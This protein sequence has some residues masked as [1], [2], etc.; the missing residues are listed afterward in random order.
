MKTYND[1]NR[2]HELIGRYFDA[3]ASEAE[4]RELKQALASTKLLTAEIE[5]ARAVLGYY[6]VSKKATAKR[7]RITTMPR[8]VAASIAA[9]I[10][11][12]ATIA[13]TLMMRDNEIENRCIAYVNGVEITDQE[14]VMS[15][16]SDNFRSLGDTAG[17]VETEIESQLSTIA[18]ELTL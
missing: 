6:A 7:R 11:I 16:I 12:A 18:A 1:I 15:I 5:E 9:A 13:T 17:S 2:I 3:S 10:A 8:T 4:E 14:H